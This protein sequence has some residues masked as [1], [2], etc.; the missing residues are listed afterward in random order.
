[1]E[2]PDRQKERPNLS[3]RPNTN[4]H[5]SESDSLSI[6]GDSR[7]PSTIAELTND[8]TSISRE[9]ALLRATAPP[10]E[11]HNHPNG[12]AP[13][14]H[15]LHSLAD[16][17]R[18][19]EALLF[20]LIKNS[21]GPDVCDKLRIQHSEI[22]AVARQSEQGRSQESFARLAQLL[23]AHI[24]TEENVVYWYVNLQESPAY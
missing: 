7:R 16:H 6:D 8:H 10:V 17:F 18:K 2:Q 23:R 20:P 12:A 4:H 13:F 19:E 15:L 5:P 21:L 14:S 9:L 11:T 1:M 24:S 22:M 3:R